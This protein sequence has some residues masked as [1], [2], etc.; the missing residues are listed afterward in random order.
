MILKFHVSFSEFDTK[1]NVRFNESFK[2]HGETEYVMSEVGKNPNHLYLIHRFR[3]CI[4][5]FEI[6]GMLTIKN[7]IHDL[8]NVT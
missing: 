5:I 3:T 2:S 8:V 1:Q 7:N 4:C 6:K